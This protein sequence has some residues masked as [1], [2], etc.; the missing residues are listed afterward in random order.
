MIFKYKFIDYNSVADF[1][2]DIYTIHILIHTYT[3]SSSSSS[4]VYK[5]IVAKSYVLLSWL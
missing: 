1:N 2:T 3:Y 4:V 5:V